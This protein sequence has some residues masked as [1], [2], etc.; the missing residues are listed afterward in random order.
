[1]YSSVSELNS[2]MSAVETSLK[3]LVAQNMRTT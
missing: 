3:I 2:Y 1:M